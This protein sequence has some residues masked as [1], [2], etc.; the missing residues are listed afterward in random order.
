MLCTMTWV[1]SWS[2]NL[3]LK[4][5]LSLWSSLR[6]KQPWSSSEN[7]K[8]IYIYVRVCRKI[9]LGITDNPGGY[10]TIWLHLSPCFAVSFTL[11]ATV[12][13]VRCNVEFIWTKKCDMW[14]LEDSPQRSAS[15]LT[16][17]GDNGLGWRP[18]NE[19]SGRLVTWNRPFAM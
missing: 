14:C 8:Y 12:L 9:S 4:L 15:G 1:S 6:N 2:K 10:C 18:W 17:P 11:C 3:F 19:R 13:S 7:K 16:S 5:F